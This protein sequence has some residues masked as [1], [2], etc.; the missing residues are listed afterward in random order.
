M[1]S[2]ED[3]VTAV[4]NLRPDIVIGMGDVLFGHKPGV[5]RLER[6]GDRTLAWIGDLLEGMVDEE[7]GT[8]SSALFA[9]ILPIE[10]DI[11]RWYLESLCDTLV[12][13]IS[14]LAV[15]GLVSAASVP[16]SL[17]HLP[18]FYAEPLGTP[19]DVLDTIAAGLDLVTVSFVNE[20]S[21]AGT[22]LN[23]LFPQASS[24]EEGK[25]K[26]P[27]GLDLWQAMFATDVSSL[28][29]DCK[30][31]TCRNHHRAYI[32]H[33]FN[34]RE[35]LG[36]VLLQVHNYHV[37]SE[38]FTAIREALLEGR[39]QECKEEFHQEY[40]EDFPASTGEGPRYAR[41]SRSPHSRNY[42]ID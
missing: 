7:E 42:G 5:K 31:Y 30:C 14:G 35:M 40:K 26:V 36:W 16:A 18:R 38:F 6:M 23:F 9:P 25:K 19:H 11:Q 41:V 29:A 39:F 1:L 37:L 28:S 34:A 15:Y 2:S 27:L 21:D 10:P 13:K 24:P 20:V 3:Y 32:H 4:Q 17:G 12:D 22:A 8:P 33:L